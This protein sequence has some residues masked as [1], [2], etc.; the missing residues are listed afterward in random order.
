MCS[1]ESLRFSDR[2]VPEVKN[3]GGQ[4]RGGFSFRQHTQK[5]FQV[6]RSAAGDDRD[7]VCRECR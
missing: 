6:T 1:Q 5:M 7:A 3:A 2:V 4:D